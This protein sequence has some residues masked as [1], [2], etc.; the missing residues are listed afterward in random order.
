MAP[1]AL[2]EDKT[3]A[4]LAKHFELHPTHIVEWKRQLLEHAAEVFAGAAQALEPV[5]LAPLHAKIGQ[6]A[7]EN[8]FLRPGSDHS[9]MQ[10]SP[11]LIASTVRA[12]RAATTRVSTLSKHSAIHSCPT[13]PPRCTIANAAMLIAASGKA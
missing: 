8:D 1:A 3:P 10:I 5:D 13:P 12:A 4:E 11:R 9:S 2:R 7:P 6:L